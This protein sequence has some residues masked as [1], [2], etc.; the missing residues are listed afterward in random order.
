MTAMKWL[1]AGL[2][3]A[4][5]AQGQD[6]APDGGDPAA[7]PAPVE[8]VPAPK[9]ASSRVS[10]VTVYRGNALVTRVVE[11]PAGK[12][13]IELVVTPLPSQTIPGSLYGEGGD[14]IRVLTTRYRSRAV[15]ED[16]REAVRAKEAEIR[17]LQAETL[18]IG[19]SKAAAEQ[20]LQLLQ[21]LET[22]TTA[23][24]Q[25]LTDKGKFDGEA[26]I[27]LSKF[28]MA[29][30]ADR[31]TAGV[32][33]ELE[34]KANEEAIQFSQ[35]QLAELS[36][37]SERTEVDAVIAVDKADAPAGTIRLSYMISA[38]SWKPQYRIRAGG[39]KDPVRLEYLAAI[40][41][42]SG[43]DW[44]EARVTLSTAQPSLQANLPELLPLD[45]AI[46]PA[47]GGDEK[48]K[49]AENAANAAEPLAADAPPDQSRAQARAYRGQA[50]HAL[51][52]NDALAG[53]ALLNQAAAM[54]Q[55]AELLGSDDK[56]DES[57][58]AATEE[59]VSVT[60]R[61]KDP[62]T[63]PSRKD[64]QLVEVAR[65][66]MTSEFFVRAVPVLSSRVYRLARMTNTSDSVL[67]AGEASMYVG[68]DFVGRMKLRQVA[69]GEPFVVGFG[70]DPQ[71]M[72]GRRMVKKTRTIQGGNQVHT[73][74]FKISVR[75]FRPSP[76][77]IQV[78]DRLPR[79]EASGEV[80]AVN[81]V[82]SQPETSTDPQY[83]RTGKADNLLRWDMVVPPDAM[84]DKALSIN[85]EFRLEYARGRSVNY[86][87]SGGLMESPIGGLSGGMGGMGGGFR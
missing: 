72:V 60:Y 71:L 44:N 70:V 82:R 36:A 19:R 81:L 55:T 37:G 84:G 16:T 67:L 63:V 58:E 32:G 83:V 34:G 57:R 68:P 23:T 54:D 28:I 17:Q 51:I 26:T 78:W 66:E 11:V 7:V 61:L 52:G 47:P 30:R 69:I 22:F 80:A 1:V 33:L 64:P 50:A 85:Y 74:E 35:R 13:S 27:A 10:A 14:G 15:R 65:S 49:E 20:D 87:S 62:L 86:L 31:V 76:V 59:G 41:Q 21:K 6:V 5:S 25:G 48:G 46:G 75:G 12:G 38:A 73:Y 18:K 29:S 42:H 40:E 3:L 9:S 79:A 45:I 56:N 2:V 24:M 39:E 77:K 43:E 53:G 4:S 8:N